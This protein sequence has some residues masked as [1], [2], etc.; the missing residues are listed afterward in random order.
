MFTKSIVADL[1]NF[2]MCRPDFYSSTCMLVSLLVLSWE[3]SCDGVVN[4]LMQRVLNG[5]TIKLKL[6]AK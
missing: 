2:Q 3:F 1:Q 4:G 5:I 6:R